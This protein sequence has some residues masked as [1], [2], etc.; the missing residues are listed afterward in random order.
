MI[1][2]FGPLPTTASFIVLDLRVVCVVM[3][4]S[5]LVADMRIE[6]SMKEQKYDKRQYR[7]FCNATMSVKNASLRMPAA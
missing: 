1:W 5:L 3:E 7:L 2:T 4:E 6:E